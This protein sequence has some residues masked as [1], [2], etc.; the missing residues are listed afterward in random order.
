MR[1]N[2]KLLPITA[3]VIS[4]AST[5]VFAGADLCH[6]GSCG[7]ITSLAISDSH[8]TIWYTNPGVV[9]DVCRIAEV[10]SDSYVSMTRSTVDDKTFDRAY[11]MA[12]AAFHSQIET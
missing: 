10:S 12:L 7:K 8:F 3:A 1:F 4:F 5:A 6:R 11:S 2:K 9:D